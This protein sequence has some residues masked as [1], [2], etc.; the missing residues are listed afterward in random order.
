MTSTSLISSVEECKVLENSRLLSSSKEGLKVLAFKVTEVSEVELVS[1]PLLKLITGN[2]V[3]D[4][5]TSV[6]HDKGDDAF[7]GARTSVWRS[8]S[9]VE[10]FD[11]W[12]AVNIIAVS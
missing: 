1:G 9:F 11:R 12:E 7:N 4:G 3:R 5:T 10:E 6:L 2:L 8:F